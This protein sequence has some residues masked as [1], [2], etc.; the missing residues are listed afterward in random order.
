MPSHHN[1]RS[2]GIAD[3]GVDLSSKLLHLNWLQHRCFAQDL[4][5]LD[6]TV[7]QFY[8]LEALVRLGGSTTMGALSREVFQVSATMTG[9]IDRLVRAGL[10]ERQRS[11]DDRRSVVVAITPSGS[12]IVE[13]AWRCGLD[14]FDEIVTRMSIGELATAGK[15]IDSLMMTMERRAAVIA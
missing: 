13:T 7:P 2:H 1:G 9:I 12:H 3:N 8:T 15:L 4:A 5:A 6:L 11:D 14:S 10:V